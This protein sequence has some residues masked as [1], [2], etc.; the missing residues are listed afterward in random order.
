MQCWVFCPD[1]SILVDRENSKMT[2]FNLDFCKGCG[3]CAVQC[4]VN[5]KI[6]RKADEEI[7]QDDPRLCIRMIEE[8]KIED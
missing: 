8:G 6:I 7:G 5:Q 2:G 4:P 1:S 3:I